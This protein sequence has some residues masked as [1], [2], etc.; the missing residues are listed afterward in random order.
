MRHIFLAI[1]VSRSSLTCASKISEK[2]LILGT[3]AVLDVVVQFFS[4]L[5]LLG[6]SCVAFGS[7]FFNVS[8]HGRLFGYLSVR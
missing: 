4:L 8:F 5:K 6:L 2:M 7:V 1:D 3:P